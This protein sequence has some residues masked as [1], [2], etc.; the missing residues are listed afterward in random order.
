MNEKKILDFYKKS[1]WINYVP[2]IARYYEAYIESEKNDIKEVFKKIP[3]KTEE[4]MAKFLEIE[5]FRKFQMYCLVQSFLF[6]EK[7]DRSD[8]DKKKMKIIDLKYTEEAEKMV[9]KYVRG[10][11]ANDYALRTQKRNKEQIEIL[12]NELVDN[13]IK[14]E[15]IETYKN[16]FIN[17]ITKGIFTHK[18]SDPT[19]KGVVDLKNKLL[20][21]EDIPL[22]IEKIKIFMTG[23]YDAEKIWNKGEFYRPCFPDCKNFFAKIGKSEIYNDIIKNCKNFHIYRVLPNRQGHSNEK[24]SYWAFGYDTLSEYFK[25]LNEDGIN[26]Y[27]SVHYNCCGINKGVNEIKKEK[28]DERKEKRREFKKSQ[29][30]SRKSST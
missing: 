14:S 22:K 2:F 24:P 30:S 6:K 25:A 10:Q 21:D 13:M 5:D 18:I 15:T 19:S 3:E 17:G 1:Y 27:K 16:L 7:Q 11:Y 26:N 8:S 9:K 23:S 12:K 29:R 20:S 28:R 4:N